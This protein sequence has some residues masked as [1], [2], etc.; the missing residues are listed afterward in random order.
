L[1]HLTAAQEKELKA[2]MHRRTPRKLLAA[3]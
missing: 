2:A 1:N 3:A